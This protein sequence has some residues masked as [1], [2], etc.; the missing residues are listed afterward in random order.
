MLAF[1]VAPYS[2]AVAAG[3]TA[4][5]IAVAFGEPTL[6]EALVVEA[7]AGPATVAIV[8]TAAAANTT[9]VLDVLLMIP[10]SIQ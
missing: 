5:S 1:G 9:S 10:P 2:I 4:Y 6:S 7:K 8:A 3:A